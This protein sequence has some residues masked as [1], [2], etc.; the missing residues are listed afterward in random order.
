MTI[1]TG[2]NKKQRSNASKEICEIKPVKFGGSPTDLANKMAL[3][4]KDHIK[5]VN[6]WN[7]L[8]RKQKDKK[9]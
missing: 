2:K 1:N 5:Y 6:Y 9:L 7:Q 4:R 8:L 3:D